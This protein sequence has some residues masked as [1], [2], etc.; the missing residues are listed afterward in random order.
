MKILNCTVGE[1]EIFVKDPVDK[2]EVV[3]DN[4]I[5]EADE[6]YLKVFISYYCCHCSRKI[7]PER[8]FSFEFL[9]KQENDYDCLDCAKRNDFKVKGF[10][11]GASGHNLKIVKR[12]SDI[13]R[14][15]PVDEGNFMGI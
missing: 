12:L 9:G 8:V 3:S 7:D 5:P 6:E 10:Y 14:I 2:P 4:E 11:V 15:A 13:E 1:V